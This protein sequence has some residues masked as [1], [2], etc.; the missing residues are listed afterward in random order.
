MANVTFKQ[1][2]FITD[3]LTQNES[4]RIIGGNFINTVKGI[5]G[6]TTGMSQI[7][8]GILLV[9]QGKNILNGK[10]PGG[11]QGSPASSNP[12]LTLAYQEFYSPDP[13]VGV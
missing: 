5:N 4:S 8:S 13:L 12:G 9:D 11:G 2:I 3:E 10:I 6:I 7:T 1:L